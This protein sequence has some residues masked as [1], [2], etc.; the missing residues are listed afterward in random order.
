[1]NK[2]KFFRILTLMGLFFMLFIVASYFYNIQTRGEI[3]KNKVE[4]PQNFAN[5]F[6]SV[7]VKSRYDDM[8]L[9][10]FMSPENNRVNWEVF[11]GNY[12]LVNFWATWCGPCV[13]ELPSLH[14]LQKKYEGKGLDVISI[15]I[16]TMRG[17]EDIKAFLKNRGIGEFAAYFDD[18]GEVQKNITLRGIP[19][20]YLLNPEGQ[21]VAIF[22]GD[23]NWASFASL[24]YFEA[25]LASKNNDKAE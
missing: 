19:T 18:V 9:A 11:S 14:K 20:T 1:M 2:Q 16:D 5:E 24:S 15:S 12:L 6:S 21:I 23:A 22:E 3:V 17:H 10:T 7:R 8:N 13:V 4:V 25:L